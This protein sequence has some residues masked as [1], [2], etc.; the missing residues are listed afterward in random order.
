MR[1]STRVV[2]DIET[3]TIIERESFIYRGSVGF[4][5]G[6]D[7][8]AKQ[9]QAAADAQ[10][11]AAKTMSG[12]AASRNAVQQPFLEDLTKNGLGYLPQMLDY[13]NGTLAKS[14]APERAALN[15]NLAGF[16]DTLPSGFKTQTQTDFNSKEGNL[17]DQNVVNALNTNQSAKMSAAEQLNPLGYYGGSTGANSSVLSAPP[18]QSGGVGNFLGGAASGLLNAA[19]GSKGGLKSLFSL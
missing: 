3:G 13:T 15:R 7:S 5:C 16:G 1:V 10:A 8:L 6:G 9:K 14:E 17:F 4:V 18:V 19:A 2:I 11:Q 12:I